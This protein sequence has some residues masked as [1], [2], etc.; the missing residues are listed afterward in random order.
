MFHKD[1]VGSLVRVA[2]RWGTNAVVTLF[3]FEE[4]YTR[5]LKSKT[6]GT[7]A[8]HLKEEV[9]LVIGAFGSDTGYSVLIPHG[10]K[11]VPGNNPMAREAYEAMTISYAQIAGNP[12][13]GR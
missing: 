1:C 8:Y 10:V 9:I 11:H 2:H 4:S 3:Y 6:V 5:Q 7:Y 12:Q 13:A